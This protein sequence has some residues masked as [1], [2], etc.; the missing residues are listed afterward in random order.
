MVRLGAEAEAGHRVPGSG[1]HLDGFVR[2]LVGGAGA[3]GTEARHCG[4]RVGWRSTN[5]GAERREEGPREGEG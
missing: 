2:V 5:L 4:R 3:G 1:S